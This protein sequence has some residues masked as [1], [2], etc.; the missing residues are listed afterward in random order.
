M[1]NILFALTLALSVFT[2]PSTLSAQDV[3]RV[4]E[5]CSTPW[6]DSGEGDVNEGC[7]Q[8]AA[9]ASL[10]TGE[11]VALL[12]DC[13]AQGMETA[14]DS[15]PIHSGTIVRLSSTLPWNQQQLKC[16]GTSFPSGNYEAVLVYRGTTQILNGF[17][18]LDSP[19]GNYPGNATDAFFLPQSA[20]WKTDVK[21]GQVGSLAGYYACVY[22]QV[23]A[24]QVSPRTFALNGDHSFYLKFVPGLEGACLYL[25]NPATASASNQPRCTGATGGTPTVNWTWLRTTNTITL[26]H[27][28]LAGANA[29]PL[30]GFVNNPATIS[31]KALWKDDTTNRGYVQYETNDGDIVSAMTAND[32]TFSLVEDN[33]DLRICNHLNQILDDGCYNILG[34]FGPFWHDANFPGGVRTVAT[35]LNTSISVNGG[36]MLLSFD[37]PSGL[38]AGSQFLCNANARNRSTAGTTTHAHMH[39]TTANAMSEIGQWGVC[40]LSNTLTTGSPPGDP[41]PGSASYINVTASSITVQFDWDT[42]G[43]GSGQGKAK[44]RVNGSGSS[45][46]ATAPQACSGTSTG[47]SIAIT[48]LAAGTTYDIIRVS[49]RADG[50]EFDSATGTQATASASIA[51]F[52]IS[53]TG[54]GTTCSSG[55]PC[56]PQAVASKLAPGIV[57]E[58][59]G[60]TYQGSDEML[61]F[62][63]INGSK[64][65][66]ITIRCKSGQTCIF[67]G[68]GVRQGVYLSNAD[69][70]VIEDI[71]CANGGGSTSSCVRLGSG[72]DNNIVRRSIAYNGGFSSNGNTG[73]V[74]DLVA[75]FGYGRKLVDQP[76][77]GNSGRMSRCWASWESRGPAGPSGPASTISAGYNSSNTLI[78][79]CIGTWD[80]SDTDP[81]G[82]FRVGPITTSTADRNIKVLGSLGYVLSGQTF[83]P[84][85]LFYVSD[86]TS[87]TIKDVVLYSEQSSKRPFVLANVPGSA[88]GPV[89]SGFLQNTTEIGGDSSTIGSEWQVSDRVDVATVGAAPN[90]WNGAGDQGARICKRYVNGVLTSLPLFDTEWQTFFVTRLNAALTNF[91]YTPSTVFAGSTDL[92]DFLQD[93][94]GTIP[95]A[96][97]S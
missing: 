77:S 58:A 72:A 53:S 87:V 59:L 62:A 74:F 38:A 11:Y 6:D 7:P 13:I 71:W 97:K 40:E 42:G 26:D 20:N 4:P 93:K 65:N 33:F 61:T 49:I 95:A 91:G 51:D 43:T 79:N 15:D 39:G 2:L 60:G 28:D 22:T 30:G 78:E 27:G 80:A 14:A 66:P 45:F 41:T 69:W 8:S 9:F 25:R 46:V 88:G 90:V 84:S 32:G 24:N 50:V 23:C 86:H 21:I 82:I 37:L 89:T 34:N 81:Q 18:K 16:S 54:S 35:N 85:R 83:A 70:F 1:R 10:A 63:G 94:F 56:K 75:A 52:T 55:S 19:L 92:M 3:V 12:E 36:K 96:C 68:Q 64:A 31:V 57:V 67:D 44:Y 73:N 29:M 76:Q 47:C 17:V 5:D 48:G